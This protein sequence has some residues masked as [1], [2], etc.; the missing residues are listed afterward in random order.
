MAKKNKP[1][2]L[3]VLRESKGLSQRGLAAKINVSAGAIAQ[4]EVGRR[5]P[6]LDIGL[7]IASFFDVPVETIQFDCREA[8]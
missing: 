8:R 6:T 4:Y 1:I 2:P 7:K 5:K 3:T